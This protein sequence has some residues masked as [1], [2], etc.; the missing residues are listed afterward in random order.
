MKKYI[1]VKV[2]EFQLECWVVINLVCSVALV[3]FVFIVPYEFTVTPEQTMQA[4]DAVRIAYIFMVMFAIFIVL[5][6]IVFFYVSKCY[7][8][9]NE[10]DESNYI[11]ED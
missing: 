10:Q 1:P 7:D 4:N 2:T 8:K 9:Y 6:W 3:M 11:Q 5:S